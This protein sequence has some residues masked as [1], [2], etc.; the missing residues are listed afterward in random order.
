MRSLV[1][2]YRLANGEGPAMLIRELDK[3]RNNQGHGMCT[4]NDS[5]F[6]IPGYNTD[7]I[8]KSFFVRMI[9]MWNTLPRAIRDSPSAASFKKSVYKR[10]LEKGA[11]R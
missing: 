2:F 6:F 7:N 11:G 5:D 10:F 3:F 4:R 9:K 1:L 8:G